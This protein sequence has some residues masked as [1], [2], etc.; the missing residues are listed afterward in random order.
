MGSGYY[1]YYTKNISIT[2]PS[3]VAV[4]G[5]TLRR[6][7]DKTSGKSAIHMVNAWCSRSNLILGQLKTAEKSNE[8]TAVPELLNIF[9]IKGRLVTADT[10]SC[11]KT[12]ADTCIEQ[13]ADYLLAVKGNQPTM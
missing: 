7:H 3:V 6:S 2:L 12:M 8:I 4:D 1:C 5:K 11:Q 10:M 13:G 9:G